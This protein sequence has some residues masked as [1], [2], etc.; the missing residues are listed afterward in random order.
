MSKSRR[1]N[2]I[3]NRIVNINED[4]SED[5]SE[6][7]QYELDQSKEESEISKYI[8]SGEIGGSSDSEE[9][10]FFKVCRNKKRMRILSSF[11]SE[12]ERMSTSSISQNVM[13]E[14]EIVVDGTQ[15][16]KLKAG[17]SGGKTPVR[18]IFKDIARSIGYAKK[19]ML[20]CVTSAFELI[21]DRHIME[22]IKDCT[23]T[24]AHQVLKKDWTITVA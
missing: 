4:Y 7:D 5:T 18:M 10:N 9:E 2:K 20:G 11:D 1:Y 15:W 13:S 17:G 14:I 24:E 16:I 19:N 22:H 6:E 23:E 8:E 3:L 12:D 21:I